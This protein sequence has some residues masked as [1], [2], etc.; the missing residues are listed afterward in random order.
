MERIYSWPPVNL[1]LSLAPHP[2]SLYYSQG[3]SS[4]QEHRDR[5]SVFWGSR[6]QPD[7]LLTWVM[8]GKSCPLS[9]PQFPGQESEGGC[10][11]CHDIFSRDQHPGG[12]T[13]TAGETDLPG[14]M[15]A[16]RSTC[17]L[18]AFR[19][20]TEKELYR[21]HQGGG[22]WSVWKWICRNG[23]PKSKSR[24]GYTKTGIP[25]PFSE[26]LRPEV[27]PPAL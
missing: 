27:H 18:L 2:L 20:A 26:K 14:F 22:G 3:L 6:P 7:L 17:I 19:K 12:L 21:A 15:L 25:R 8:S 23:R 16:S 4:D 10:T 9:A 13:G 5:K 11:W 1:G 24:N